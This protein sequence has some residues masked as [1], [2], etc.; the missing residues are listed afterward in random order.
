MDWISAFDFMTVEHFE[1][2][3]SCP[4]C[5]G[6]SRKRFAFTDTLLIRLKAI[7]VHFISEKI[8]ASIASV[9]HSL[10]LYLYV[11]IGLFSDPFIVLLVNARHLK[12]VASSD[13]FMST[14]NFR[15]LESL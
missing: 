11:V 13:Y 8:K 1:L 9:A 10:R 7:Q 5:Q 3:F 15:N 12:S 14:L 6:S 2:Q 4:P